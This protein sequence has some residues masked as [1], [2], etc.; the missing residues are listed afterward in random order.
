M[1]LFPVD[2][3]S[4]EYDML[5]RVP[6]IGVKTANRII[7]ARRTGSLSFDGL[8]KIGVVL[9]R[10]QYFIVCSGRKAD[11]LKITE[12][13]VMRELMS[14]SCVKHLDQSGNYITDSS[15]QLSLFD[16][17]DTTKEDFLKCLT[18]QM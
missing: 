8:K 17:A 12:S 2:V 16:K 13:A 3:N 6:G 1:E 11:G 9:K 15:M 5:L 10:A 18:G 7:T 14:A 4:A